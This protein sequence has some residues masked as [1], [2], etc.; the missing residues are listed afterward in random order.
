VLHP[1]WSGQLMLDMLNACISADTARAA[2]GVSPLNRR[3]Q[4]IVAFSKVPLSFADVVADAQMD[5]FTSIP[6]ATLAS[7]ITA[8]GG[9]PS[10]HPESDA[11]AASHN[12]SLL[13]DMVLTPGQFER[14]YL[15]VIERRLSELYEALPRDAS[16]DERAQ[17]SSRVLEY[18]TD[19]CVCESL[20][21]IDA[22]WVVRLY[23]DLV[24]EA[25]RSIPRLSLRD[26]GRVVGLARA[27]LVQ[28]LSPTSSGVSVQHQGGA[29]A[30]SSS[31]LA[32]LSKQVAELQALLVGRGKISSL[33][34]GIPPPS[35]GS[36][37]RPLGSVSPISNHDPGTSSSSSSSGGAVR[38]SNAGTYLSQLSAASGYRSSSS[39][40]SG[41]LGDRVAIPDRVDGRGTQPLSQS[42]R[43]DDDSDDDDLG[44]AD[45]ASGAHRGS[46]LSLPL[47]G[48]AA[49]YFARAVAPEDS[50][51]TYLLQ[52][53]SHYRSVTQYVAQCVSV[54]L[55]A[56]RNLHEIERLA[57]LIDA[58]LD[59][60]VGKEDRA[61]ELASRMF[62]GLTLADGNGDYSLV[63]MMVGEQRSHLPLDIISQIN[64]GR[65][66]NQ[67][68]NR[69]VVEDVKQGTPDSQSGW[70]SGGG[71]RGG[72]YRS[73]SYRSRGGGQHGRGGFGARGGNTGAHP[74][75]SPSGAGQAS[76][77]RA[78]TTGG[79]NV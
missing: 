32:T 11:R 56:K 72:G 78:A 68:V 41:N 19:V 20:S 71:G 42:H 60:G 17:V 13:W 36:D 54:D 38:Q 8:L 34:D 79:P 2:A 26:G 39:S 55:K 37:G 1:K 16:A 73:D 4:L 28:F 53:C 9:A 12:K 3:H 25:L 22:S 50:F 30:T 27:E 24:P 33:V 52:N 48:G 64:K 77:G 15:H 21:S 58:M 7:L 67:R 61:L 43:S 49:K 62:F 45:I 31:Q 57:K 18:C 51:A 14:G 44:A 76:G 40:L 75:S 69:K 23:N 35:G 70:R 74:A 46:T 10:P 29:G 63:D 65:L 6:V 47:P 59:G 5:Y 66:A